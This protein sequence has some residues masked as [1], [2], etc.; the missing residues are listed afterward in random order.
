MGDNHFYL[1]PPKA[2]A[3]LFAVKRPAIT[4]H[5]KNIF[6]SNELDKMSVCSKMEHTAADNKTYLID[7]YN[8]DAIIAVGYRVN[9]KNATLFRIWATKVLKE[10]L[11]AGYVE[12]EKRLKQLEK[13]IKVIDIASRLDNKALTEE[14]ESILNVLLSYNKSLQMLDDYDHKKIAKPT[15]IESDKK[16]TYKECIIL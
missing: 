11:V 13:R 1:S 10:Y 5:L 15:G 4:K 12:N 6:N 14:A 3:E 16:I 7:F 2:I 8:L 9:S